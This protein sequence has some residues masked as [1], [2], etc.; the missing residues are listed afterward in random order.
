M[1]VS[2]EASVFVG[3]SALGALA[4]GYSPAMYSLSLELYAR[5]GG[6]PSEAG[7]LFGA[8]S[9]IQ[10]LG[11]QIVGPS[12]FGLLYIKTVATFP[13]AM[14]YAFAAAVLFALFFLFLVRIPSD[15]EATVV[16]DAVMWK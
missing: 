10:A 5:R 1:A 8:M 12:L 7:R 3:A 4:A 14:F 2:K 9:V 16:I 11:N 6:S 15:P 13:E